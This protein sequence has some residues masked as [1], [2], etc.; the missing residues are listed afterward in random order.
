MAVTEFTWTDL[1]TARIEKLSN[2][3]ELLRSNLAKQRTRAKKWRARCESLGDGK[4]RYHRE[5]EE[6]K[7]LKKPALSRHN[8][9]SMQIFCKGE[10]TAAMKGE[11]GW[12]CLNCKEPVAILL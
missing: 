12:R 5:I 11:D 7:Q 10:Q 3:N 4:A 8:E 1:L 9:E 2:D 6:Q